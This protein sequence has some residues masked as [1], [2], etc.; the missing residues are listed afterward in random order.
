MT[1]LLSHDF[2]N[3]VTTENNKEPIRTM[4]DVKTMLAPALNSVSVWSIATL[5][6]PVKIKQTFKFEGTI[7]FF[8]LASFLYY[9]N[10]YIQ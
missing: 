9:N 2:Y 8:L 10:P 4:K 5:A 1:Y 6:P 7:L 3:H